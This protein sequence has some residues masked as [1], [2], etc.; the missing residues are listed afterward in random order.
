MGHELAHLL[1]ARFDMVCDFCREDKSYAYTNVQRSVGKT[2]YGIALEEFLC[3]YIAIDV[4]SKVTK[5]D[6]SVVKKHLVDCTNGRVNTQDLEITERILSIFSRVPL[7]DDYYDALASDEEGIFQ[8]NLLLY[9][10]VHGYDMSSLISDYDEVMGEH[11]WM[12]LNQYLDR[13]MYFTGTKEA[14][15]YFEKAQMELNLFTLR[16]PDL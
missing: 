13:Y 15:E 7:E 1:F 11:A 12:H 8:K 5:N 3:D 9:E 2:R 16:C 10:A 14:E 4:T 6:K